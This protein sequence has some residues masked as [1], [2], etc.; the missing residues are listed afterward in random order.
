M[1]FLLLTKLI[2]GEW[3]EHEHGRYLCTSGRSYGKTEYSWKFNGNE[4][5][6]KDLQLPEDNDCM[7]KDGCNLACL[8]TLVFQSVPNDS[9]ARSYHVLRNHSACSNDENIDYVN[10]YFTYVSLLLFGE[11]S[12]KNEGIYEFSVQGS[13]SGFGA[14]DGTKANITISKPNIDSNIEIRSGGLIPPPTFKLAQN[15]SLVCHGNHIGENDTPQWFKDDELI[16]EVDTDVSGCHNRTYYY[17][18][19]TEKILTADYENS[20]FKLSAYS[21]N[22][23]LHWCNIT[24]ASEGNYSC[25]MPNTTEFKGV[26]VTVPPSTSLPPDKS[27]NTEQLLIIWFGVLNAILMLAIVITLAVWCWIRHS[28][29]KQKSPHSMCDVGL[30]AYLHKSL[31]LEA[32]SLQDGSDPLEFPYDQLQFLHLLGL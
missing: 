24:Q 16:D 17:T 25:R 22:A 9:S 27:S 19:H 5:N 18:V 28:A 12:T 29:R 14:V 31:E 8:K 4:L 15:M 20:Y 6:V 10:D 1:N 7:L 32:S 2:N 23:T 13:M 11:L 3:H 26:Q 21:S 30:P